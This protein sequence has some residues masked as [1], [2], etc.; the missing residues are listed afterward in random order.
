MVPAEHEG[1]IFASHEDVLALLHQAQPLG[2]KVRQVHDFLRASHPFLSRIA[3]AAYDPATDLLKTFVHS[4]DDESPLSFYQSR[5]AASASLSEIAASRRPRVVNDL[6]RHYRMPTEHAQRLRQSGY[7]ASYTMPIFHHGALYGFVFF[8][9]SQPHVFSERVVHDLNVCGH[10]LAM[11]MASELSV[12]RTLTAS[13]RTVTQIVQSRDFE[14]GSHIERVSHYSRLIG[15]HVA[16]HYGFN[17]DFLE[18]LYLFAPLH[19]IGKVGVPDAL[20][21]KPGRL[22]DEEFVVIQQHTSKGAEIIDAMLA[23][24]GLTDFP[25]A[26]MLRNI[27][28]YHHEAMDGSGYPEA[29]HGERIP[30][31][32]RIV[33]VADVFD[34]LSSRRPYKEAW[35]LDEALATIAELSGSRFD[36]PCV[37][38]LLANREALLDI[39]QR[40][41]E[42]FIG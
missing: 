34:A 14:T 38:A 30:V 26:A 1:A 39:Q 15:R 13:V 22:T 4:T 23:H 11:M 10:L 20:L 2:N 28:L 16:A 37:D 32:A 42:D 5:L 40:F 17:D 33:A 24:F 21:L 18:Y 7:G 29:L 19:D 3:M 41:A 35:G 6:E 36:A 31:E 12:V 8:N 9:A 25:Y 27:T